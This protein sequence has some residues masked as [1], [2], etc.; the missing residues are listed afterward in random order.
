M[1][2]ADYFPNP[3]P[4]STSVTVQGHV[5]T[6]IEWTHLSGRTHAVAYTTL[7]D[8]NNPCHQTLV[9][10]LSNASYTGS[11]DAVASVALALT[12]GMTTLTTEHAKW[13]NAFYPR[14]MLSFGGDA[15]M[16]Q[17]YYISVSQ[18][19]WLLS[20]PQG[21][22]LSSRVSCL[23]SRVSGLRSAVQSAVCSLQSAPISG[24]SNRVCLRAAVQVCLCHS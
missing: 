9:L 21:P 14:S 13:W 4:T 2:P 17:L 7:T 16:E 5:V 6:V 20:N 18:M 24:A 15:K 10:A 22:S 11:Q 8:A 1:Q 19:A 23:V 12:T 3:L